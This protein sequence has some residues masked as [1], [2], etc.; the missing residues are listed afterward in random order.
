MKLKHVLASCLTLA[1]AGS[2]A[3]QERL[4]PKQLAGPMEEVQSGVM[5]QV[6]PAD[7]AVHSKSAMIP[8]TLQPQ[9]NGGSAWS[10]TIAADGEI[11]RV[12]LFA[13]TES[14][15]LSVASPANK[16]RGP[17]SARQ[18]ATTLERSSLAMGS[19]D[20]LEGDYYQF[21]GQ[22]VGTWDVSVSAA[23]PAQERG[24][25]LYTSN[26]PYR[27][28]SYPIAE[29]G[30]RVGQEIGFVAYAFDLGAQRALG[31]R[32]SGESQA[33]GGVIAEASLRITDPSG[34]EQTLTMLDDGRHGDGAAGDGVFG[35]SF[36]P[37]EA[38]EFQAQVVV[39]G[40]TPEGLPMVRTSQHALPVIGG[41][42][43]LDSRFADAR[44]SSG[45][46][47]R[48]EI[49]L[50]IDASAEMPE[51]FRVFAEVWGADELGQ[52]QPVSWVGGMS[53]LENGRLTLGLDT[54]WIGL[55]KARS[56]FELRNVRVED[57]DHFIPVARAESLPVA[58]PTLPSAALKAPRTLD[59]AMFM[60]PRP[61]AQNQAAAK[62]AGGRLLLVHGYCS[63]SVWAPV[64]GQFTDAS[65]FLDL[66]QNRSH[67]QFANRIASFGSS[68]PSYGIV[69]HSQGGAAALHL[70]TYYWSG[71]D[72]AGSGRLIQSVGTPYQGTSLAG[73]LALLGQ[74]FG[75]GCG[76][77]NDLTYSGAAS[78]LSGIP[79][80]ARNKV[81]YYTTSFTDKW[82]RYDYC[83]IV[84]D[85]VLS[86]PDDG[87]TERARGQLSGA[88]NRG[89]RTGWC[90]TDGMR[91]PA[92]VRDS[93]R[94]STMN[95]NA[96]R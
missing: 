5:A 70:Y 88:V 42:A 81:N 16:S 87:T 82:W 51:K 35:A 92:Q 21:D 24:Y 7:R 61:A 18:T 56:A 34:A 37:A 73:N 69:A 74:I 75:V 6:D 20:A 12:V 67:D 95:A 55:S 4:I 89:H 63:G 84:S 39:E 44:L 59:D 71:L 45:N 3:A 8:V 60:G 49:S 9:K 62:A 53:Y 29:E 50:G 77:N 11:L 43:R 40:S 72:N 80:W 54:R 27:L 91:D 26:S 2:L 13:G 38:G 15:D 41:S 19:A 46:D 28:A 96:A 17:V 10:G 58:M 94:N 36:T 90:H 1:L 22:G 14:W 25:L 66:N 48:L 57:P 78:W 32:G 86:D 52:M 31:A 93:G 33:L 79:T 83:Q 85:L 47:G 68:F 64:A 65:I 76:T 23:A 30:Q